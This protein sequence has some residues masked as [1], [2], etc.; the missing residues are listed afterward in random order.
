MTVSFSADMMDVAGKRVIPIEKVISVEAARAFNTT[1]SATMVIPDNMDKRFFRYNARM[2]LWRRGQDGTSGLFGD[3]IWF[4]RKI[5][6]SHKDRTYTI[7]FEDAFSLLN[8]R[9]VAYT[10]DTLYADKTIETFDIIVPD[11]RLRIDNMMRQYVRENYGLLS[12]D[13]V[14]R[15]SLI[16]VEDDR[17]IAP[18]GSKTAAWARLG[19]TLLDLARMSA[20]KGM[21]L[22][23]DLVPQPDGTFVFKVWDTV[24]GVNRGDGSPSILTLSE[25]LNHLT[26]V[27]E[28]DDYSTL[29]TFVYVLGLGNGASQI[30]IGTGNEPQIRADPFGRIEYTI[31]D[32][33]IS[34]ESTLT[35]MGKASLRGRRPRRTVTARVADGSGVIYGR[36]YAYG[37]RVLAHVGAK[38]YNCHINAVR[39]RWQGGVEDLEIRLA[40]TELL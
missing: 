18:Y 17:S 9:L 15:N 29:G 40:G 20:E 39:T 23:F 5:K 24:R 16:I 22:F 30:F 21:D 32:S 10:S 3:T 33:E 38:K 25:D 12:E 4:A 6:H 26:E 34:L 14:R 8:L 2:R 27:E 31:S 36:N 19:D 7:D 37:D 35:D 1:G 28:V 13:V 11:D